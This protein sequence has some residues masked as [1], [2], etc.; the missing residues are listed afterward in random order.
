M[1]SAQTWAVSSYTTVGK[2]FCGVET[3]SPQRWD[4]VLTIG[5]IFVSV[6][7]L[8]HESLSEDTKNYL[9]DIVTETVTLWHPR[10]L[11]AL[12]DCRQFVDRTYDGLVT[13]PEVTLPEYKTSPQFLFSDSL[14]SW[15][16]WTLFDAPPTTSEER[17][18][19]RV[20]G[21]LLTHSFK[22]LWK[23]LS[24]N[25]D[26]PS[27]NSRDKNLPESQMT[28]NGVALTDFETASLLPKEEKKVWAARHYAELRRLAG[29]DEDTSPEQ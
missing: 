8:N 1:A 7:Q 25:S 10:G 16:V 29:L 12:E 27:T 14:G 2:D 21:T 9:L 28:G 20:L 24:V 19:V 6:S 11:D 26:S 17:R 22:N 23:S 4:F 5:G 3:V 13:L 18:L 15:T